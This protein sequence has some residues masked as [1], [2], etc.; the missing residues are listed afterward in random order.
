MSTA[1]RVFA[2]TAEEFNEYLVHDGIVDVIEQREA[3]GKTNDE[4]VERYSKHVKALVQVGSA[5]SG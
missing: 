4:A 1:A 5:R 2:L 3:A